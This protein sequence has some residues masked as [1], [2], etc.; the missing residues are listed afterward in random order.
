MIR[1]NWLSWQVGFWRHSK[2]NYHSQ[3]G[4]LMIGRED[5]YD[6]DNNIGPACG[7]IGSIYI[8]PLELRAQWQFDQWTIGIVAAQELNDF[9][10]NFLLWSVEIEVGKHPKW[11]R[12]DSED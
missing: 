2:I 4:P 1:L 8:G 12:R 10:L 6:L 7:E 5:D 11:K 3:I 9:S